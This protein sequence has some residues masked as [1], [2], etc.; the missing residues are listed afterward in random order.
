VTLAASLGI[1]IGCATTA[2]LIP[3]MR[4]MRVDAAVALRAL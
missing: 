3:V 4:S 1:L 2:L